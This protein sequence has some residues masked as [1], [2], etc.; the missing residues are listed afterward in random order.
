MIDLHCHMLPGIDDGPTDLETALEMARVAVADGIT[1]TA[2]TP[3]IYPG[4]FENDARSISA[5]AEAFRGHLRSAGI[6]LTITTGADIQIVPELLDGLKSGRFP[7]LHGSRY[8]LFEPPH[9]TVPPRFLDTIFD[10]LSAGFVP[11]ITHPERLTWLDDK[12]YGWF[13]EAARQGAWIQ[14]TAGAVTGRFREQPQY[15]A[16]RFLDDGLVHLLA[17]DAHHFQRRPPCWRKDARRRPNGW[18]RRRRSGWSWIAPGR[19]SR[20][21]NRI[22]LFPPGVSGDR[23]G[24]G[25]ARIQGR[26][27]WISR[28]FRQKSGWISFDLA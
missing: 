22:A 14:V 9:H 10:A 20:T 6:P 26:G 13:V 19:S 3:H 17:T 24:M 8:F 1:L 18:G 5:A 25:T 4:L 21:R 28:W 2:C 15:W 23:N 16:E 27:G 12:H 11:V 7:C